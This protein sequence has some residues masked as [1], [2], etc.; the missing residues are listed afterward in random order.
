MFRLNTLNSREVYQIIGMAVLNIK[1]ERKTIALMAI[2]ILVCTFAKLSKSA[3]TC[4]NGFFN[5]NDEW[6]KCNSSWYTCTNQ[7]EW[8]SC[9]NRILNNSTK[10]WEFCPDGQYYSIQVNKWLDWGGSWL[11]Q[12]GYQLNWYT[13]PGSQNFDINL[14]KWVDNCTDSQLFI[15]DSLMR[16]IPVWRDPEYYI[17]SN[18][19]QNIELGTQKYPFKKVGLSTMEILNYFSHTNYNIT[20][21]IKE[22]TSV[23]LTN[24]R[25]FYLDIPNLEYK[26]YSDTGYAAKSASITIIDTSSSYFSESTQFNIISDVEIR[27]TQALNRTDYTSVEKDIS[28]YSTAIIIANRCNFKISNFDVYR[29]VTADYSK[30]TPFIYSVYLQNHTLTMKDINF[31]I[32]GRILR[33][34][35]PMSLYAENIYMDFYGMMGGIYIDASWNYPEASKTG[36]IFLNNITAINSQSRIADF[37]SGVLYYSGPANV[38]VQN[39]NILIYG[40]L[41]FDKSELEI[42]LNE[43]WLPNDGYLQTIT[44]QNNLF[45]LPSNPNNDRFVE[46]FIDVTSAYPRAII[47]SFNKNI[48]E[49]IV[50]NVY[51]IFYLFFTENTKIFIS[52]T[53]ISNVSS[54]SG[55]VTITTMKDVTLSNSTFMNSSDFG[56]NLFYFSSVQNVTIADVTIEN[57]NAT[58]K[59]TDFLFLF[60][61][62]NRGT[63]SIDSVYMKNVNIGLQMGFYQNGI[64]SIISFT[65]S[66]FTYVYIGNKNKIISTGQ[67]NSIIFKNLTFI[68]MFDQYSSDTQNDLFILNVIDLSNPMDS[69]ISDIYVQTS[70]VDFFKINSVV[71]I[72][73]VPVYVNF[74]DITYRDWTLHFKESLITVGNIESQEQ[75]Y[76]CCSIII[77]SPGSGGINSKKSEVIF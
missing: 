59:S 27:L 38:T 24:L 45:S 32:S 46:T 30:D 52:D 75:I 57:V 53:M 12:W 17:D 73:S 7:N 25:N 9:Y 51:P 20:I 16:N 29:N 41:S 14:L 62:V 65:N 13:C 67:F 26:T 76:I 34:S 66:Y 15:Q 3:I 44:I 43:N 71:G 35:Q 5:F 56:H 74:T 11:E 2:L 48:I 10:L 47:A 1:L 22:N 28:V 50:S 36:S 55:I 19:L 49:N 72:T 77:P 58:G 61:I 42:Q 39:S 70:T 60:D 21:Y 23:T 69:I 18:S 6:I 4:S 40:A 54:Q 8:T 64:A 31:Y 68:E 63:I 33:S 37:R